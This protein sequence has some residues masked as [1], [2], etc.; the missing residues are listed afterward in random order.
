[1]P[2]T[3]VIGDI[4]GA[5][6]A[7]EQL[8]NRLAPREEDTLIF[9]GDY[10]DG[11]SESAAV[12]RYLMLLELRFHCVFVR[13]NHDVSCEAWLK[14]NTPEGSW[15]TK[16]GKATVASYLRLPEEERNLHIGFF[17]RMRDYYLDTRNRLFIH[18]GFTTLPEVIYKDR[19][20]W[21]LALTMDKRVKS[22][23]ALF[24]KKLLLFE[25]IYIGHTPTLIHGEHV[26]MK[27]CNV[28]NMDTGAGFT[29]KISAMEV[30]TKQVWQSDTVQLLYPDEKGRNS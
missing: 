28:Y 3:Y 13:G 19:S 29:G 21:D 6:K 22:N 9:L 23:P 2:A 10:V 16:S 17:S 26:P 1:M 7:L 24:P 15:L 12:I 4:H 14:G 8:I 27:A 5:C 20:L 18:A 11:W 30:A 25:E